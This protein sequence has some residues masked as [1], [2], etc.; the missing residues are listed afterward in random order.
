MD[1]LVI[2]SEQFHKNTFMHSGDME[3]TD[4]DRLTR[5]TRLHA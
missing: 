5:T 4:T 1:L 3:K 2:N